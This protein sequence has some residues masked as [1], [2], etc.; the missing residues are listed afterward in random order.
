MKEFIK[1]KYKQYQLYKKILKDPIEAKTLKDPIEAEDLEHTTEDKYKKLTQIVDKK[2]EYIKDTGI[3]KLKEI[4]SLMEAQKLLIKGLNIKPRLE[5]L[6]AW[7]NSELKP[8]HTVDTQFFI[9]ET[10]DSSFSSSWPIYTET[11]S[12]IEKS[13]TKPQLK[14]QNPLELKLHVSSYGGN[15]NQYSVE[16]RSSTFINKRW[17]DNNLD[18][19]FTFLEGY[20]VN[21]IADIKAKEKI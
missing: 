9:S 10:L 6:V 14:L 20:F 11:Y 18:E 21:N 7:L 16:I 15:A 1:N 3:A 12:L 17:V 4:E 5:K 19:A 2:A 8:L 13:T